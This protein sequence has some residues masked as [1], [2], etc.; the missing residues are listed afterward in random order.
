MQD[1]GRFPWKVKINA[2]RQAPGRIIRPP[3]SNAEGRAVD[4][5]DAEMKA[6][7]V[8]VGGGFLQPSSAA[9]TIKVR[10]G[11]VL[12]SDG[13]LPM[14]LAASRVSGSVGSV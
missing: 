12:V 4:A 5:R 6:R 13:A 14:R 9:T 11:E 1:L 3:E 10:D 8:I 2:T 7:G